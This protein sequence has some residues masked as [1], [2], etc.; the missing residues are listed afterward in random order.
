MSKH[1]SYVVQSGRAL[2][3]SPRES[4]G[5]IQVSGLHRLR[6]LEPMLPR[7]G[8]LAVW[9]GEETGTSAWEVR[10]P[11]ERL[12]LMLSPELYRGFSGEGQVLETLAGN[13]WQG[14]LSRMRAQLAWQARIDVQ[15]LAGSTGLEA[16]RVETALAVLGERG[17]AGYDVT[18]GSYFHR[19]LPFDLARL[20]ELQPRLQGA[21]RLLAED[22]ARITEIHGSRA[23]DVAVQGS[24]V[25]H[26]VRLR[27]EVDRCTCP[28]FGRHQGER[29]PCKH[30]LAA[31]LLAD[32]EQDSEGERSP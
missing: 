25:T 29:G 11:T 24:Q 9:S 5:A 28:W 7:A 22:G 2:R 6:V 12:L 16:A 14:A 17:L 8:G 4:P 23:W 10:F 30:I 19:E 13:A 27:P 32:G 3:V 18:T 21:R 26:Q 31:R 20:E 15:D 1:P